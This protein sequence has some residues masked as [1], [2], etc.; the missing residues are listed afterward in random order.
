MG[1]YSG[2]TPA[3][4]RAN[5]K[6]LT[7]KVDNIL[8]RVPKGKKAEIQDI[9]NE[10]GISVNQFIVDAIDHAI[11]Q[12][13]NSGAWYHVSV[14]LYLPSIALCSLRY[15]LFSAFTDKYP[16]VNQTALKRQIQGRVW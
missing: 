5:E 7:T 14:N 6:Y 10:Q 2:Y 4:K 13:H 16:S 3:K 11:D 9:A 1:K 8:V 12:H 15:G